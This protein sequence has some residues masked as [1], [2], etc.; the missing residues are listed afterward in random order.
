MARTVSDD[1]RLVRPGFADSP[2]TCAFRLER[3]TGIE[4]ALSAWELAC[5]ALPTTVFAAH[6]LFALSVSARYR[7][8]QTVPSGTQRA[9]PVGGDL[10]LVSYRHAVGYRRSPGNM[11]FRRLTP[12]AGVVCRCGQRWW[13][14]SGLTAQETLARL[15]RKRG[16]GT[17]SL[18]VVKGGARPRSRPQLRRPYERDQTVVA[19]LLFPGRS[20]RANTP[21][22]V[23]QPPGP[24]GLPATGSAEVP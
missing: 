6:R 13:S 21:A 18:L 10:S 20:H 17:T 3:V 16:L 7:P 11:A 2:L 5:H 15:L 4:P 8:S 19:A 22:A 1:P 23:V 14:A 9:R 24:G 12:S